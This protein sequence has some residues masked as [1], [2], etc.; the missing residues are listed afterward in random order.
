MYVCLFK[1][2]LLVHNISTNEKIF[3]SNETKKDVKRIVRENIRFSDIMKVTKDLFHPN[4]AK[5]TS[6]DHVVQG[7]TNTVHAPK[8]W[9][10]TSYQ[11]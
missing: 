4:V 6:Y 2:E 5:L 9:G 10:Q 11:E 3:E 1:Q 7:E 8:G